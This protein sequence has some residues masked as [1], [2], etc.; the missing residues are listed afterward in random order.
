MIC[1]FAAGFILGI[2]FICVLAAWVEG[3]GKEDGRKDERS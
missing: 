3:K 2:V 1:Y